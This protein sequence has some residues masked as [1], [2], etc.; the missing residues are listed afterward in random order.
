MTNHEKRIARETKS[1]KRVLAMLTRVRTSLEGNGP[2]QCSFANEVRQS[3]LDSNA[4]CQRIL[5]GRLRLL[6]SQA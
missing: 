3:A 1:A 2:T 5:I 4:G 6:A